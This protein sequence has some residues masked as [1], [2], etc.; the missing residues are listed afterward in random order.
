MLHGHCDRRSVARWGTVHGRSAGFSWV[1][2]SD[3]LWTSASRVSGHRR[4]H[5]GTGWS[6][7][8]PFA[9]TLRWG[10]STATALSISRFLL[11]TPLASRDGRCAPGHLEGA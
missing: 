4:D 7:V 6:M 8:S 10:T 3:V 5:P 2:G 1:R 11:W 9:G